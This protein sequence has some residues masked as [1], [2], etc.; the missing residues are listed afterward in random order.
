MRNKPFLLGVVGGSL[1]CTVLLA[2]AT[3]KQPDTGTPE[4]T[5]KYQVTIDNFTFAPATLTVPAGSKVAWVNRDDAPH[6]VA[7]TGKAFPA[8]PV[9]DTGDG[10]SFSFVKPGTYDYFCSLHPH[11]VGK[12]IVR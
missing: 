4:K 3:Q 7:S 12:I 6:K 11:M 1:L 8:S 2:A 10:Y 5:G 9:L